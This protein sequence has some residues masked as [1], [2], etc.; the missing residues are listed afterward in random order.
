[1]NNLITP[2]V[3]LPLYGVLSTQYSLVAVF[4]LRSFLLLFDAESLINKLASPELQV[5]EEETLV[6]AVEEKTQ[7]RRRKKKKLKYS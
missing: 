3:V 2:A 6:T 7:P 4:P 5:G 1:M